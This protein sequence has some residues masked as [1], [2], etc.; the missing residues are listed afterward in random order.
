MADEKDINEVKK[1]GIDYS[2]RAFMKK[3]LLTGIAVATTAAITKK[4]VEAVP[5]HDLRDAYLNDDLQ[6]DKVMK[7]KKYVLMT[8]EEKEQ[9][10]QTLV[11]EYRYT[12]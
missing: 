5:K 8:T 4:V 12:A 10:V 1:E 11:S 2:R 6:Q 7:D 3:A 9:L